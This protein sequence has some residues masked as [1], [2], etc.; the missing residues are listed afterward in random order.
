VKNPHLLSLLDV[1]TATW[2]KVWAYSLEKTD[3]LSFGI[4][5]LQITI[6]EIFD[7]LLQNISIEDLLIEKISKSEYANIKDYPNRIKLWNKIPVKYQPGFVLKT[8]DAIMD[9]IVSGNDEEV[10]SILENK[11]LS[12]DYLSSFCSRNTLEPIISIYDRFA[13][14]D[15]RYLLST[16]KKASGN[17]NKSHSERLGRIVQQWRWEDSANAI[18]EKA[19]YKDDF[20]AALSQCSSLISWWY[21][22]LYSNLFNEA[23]SESDYYKLLYELAVKLYDKGPEENDIWKKAGGDVAVFSNA[24]TRQEQWH[25]AINKLQVGGGGKKITPHSLLEAMKD[26]HPYGYGAEINKLMEYFKKK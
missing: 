13:I 6:F 1:K 16:I 2:R 26:E 24:A 23:F 9:S 8:S 22:L 5:H 20:K 7:L 15:E 11:I 12:T 17:L 21:R 3:N 25:T 10:E 18:F 19:K 4:P 14:S